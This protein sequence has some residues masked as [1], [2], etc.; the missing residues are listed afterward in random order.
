[1]PRNGKPGQ[2]CMGTPDW[3][4]ARRLTQESTIDTGV[5]DWYGD[6]RLP[7]AQLAVRLRSCALPYEQN[8]CYVS[9]NPEV[10]RLAGLLAAAGHGDLAPLS[11]K[12]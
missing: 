8:S 12:R 7:P 9:Q 2:R 5:D 6:R 4:G 1:M 11:F 10:C 3:H